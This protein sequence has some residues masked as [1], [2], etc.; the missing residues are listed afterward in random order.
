MFLG[1]SPF[2]TQLRADVASLR[3]VLLTLFFGAVGMVADP[4]W[5]LKNCYFVFFIALI[6]V[7]GKAGII[8]A[9]LRAMGR[10]TRASLATGLCLAQ[11]G[12][13]AFVLGKTGKDSGV[14][15]E[16]IEMVIVSSAILTLLATPYL[17][18]GAPR[19]AAWAARWTRRAAGDGQPDA[20]EA[21]KT[22]HVIIIGFGTGRP[23]GRP[24]L[25]GSATP[26]LVL[27]LNSAARKEADTMGLECQVGDATQLDVLEHADP[28]SARLVVITLPVHR[29][30]LVV[31]EHVRAMA[32]HVPVIVRSRHERDCHKFQ[33]AGADVIVGDEKE[34][35]RRLAWQAVSQLESLHPASETPADITET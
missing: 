24:R 5:I 6:M 17:V 16:S 32:P 15:G 2:A 30:A 12:E 4:L 27:D 28:H 22:P 1:G 7:A 20:S 33:Q 11:V 29:A 34:V 8:W 23:G 25:L 21:E 19:M 3:V 18:H 10:P 35:G 14:I 26:V 31:L 13:F 9:L